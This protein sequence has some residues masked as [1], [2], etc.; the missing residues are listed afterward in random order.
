MLKRI[1]VFCLFQVFRFGGDISLS[2][3]LPPIFLKGQ[4]CIFLQN[5]NSPQKNSCFLLCGAR[6]TWFPAERDGPYSMA[7]T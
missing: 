5:L 3:G 1:E 2:P 7:I 4:E 6:K